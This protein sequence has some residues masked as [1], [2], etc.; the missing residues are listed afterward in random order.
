MSLKIL[1]KENL[2]PIEKD[3][4]ELDHGKGKVPTIWRRWT[5]DSYNIHGTLSTCGSTTSKDDDVESNIHQT[6]S[7]L[8]DNFCYIF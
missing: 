8:L 1:P 3:L 5:G 7:L 4:T 6:F 2:A